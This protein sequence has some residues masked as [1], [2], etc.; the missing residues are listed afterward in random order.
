MFFCRNVFSTFDPTTK[1]QTDKLFFYMTL[2]TVEGMKRKREYLH[3]YSLKFDFTF[4]D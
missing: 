2:P 3:I 1:K 4:H